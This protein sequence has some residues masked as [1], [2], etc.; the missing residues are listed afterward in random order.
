ML[1]TLACDTGL[2]IDNNNVIKLWLIHRNSLYA[3]TR[4]AWPRVNGVRHECTSNCQY[5]IATHRF[6]NP[7]K[8]T[9]DKIVSWVINEENVM[10]LLRC[11]VHATFR[12]VGDCE[13][14]RRLQGSDISYSAA[15]IILFLNR[16][17]SSKVNQSVVLLRFAI[18]ILSPAQ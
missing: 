2:W 15:T 5:H 17:V 13:L 12:N 18:A 11:H 14:C 6:Y 16:S 9:T 3:R 1:I 8:R 7:C 10:K 4:D